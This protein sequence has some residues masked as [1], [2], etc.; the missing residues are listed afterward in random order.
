MIHVLNR[1]KGGLLTVSILTIAVTIV[2]ILNIPISLAAVETNNWLFNVPANYIYDSGKVEVTGGEAILKKT[3]FQINDDEKTEF[4][5]GTYSETEWSTDHVQLASNEIKPTANTVGLWHLNNLGGL[6]LD[7]TGNGNHATNF[8]AGRGETGVYGNSFS[9]DGSAG[10]TEVSDSIGLDNMSALT[11]EAWVYPTDVTGENIILNKETTYEMGINGGLF[12]VAIQTDSMGWIWLGTKSVSPNTW[13]HVAATYDGSVIKLYINGLY[14]EQFVWVGGDV[15]DSLSDLRFGRRGA[16]SYFDGKLDEVAVWNSALNGTEIAEHAHL[17][18][19]EINGDYQSQV[20]DGGTDLSWEE[21]SWTENLSAYS[22]WW[23]TSWTKRQLVEVDNTGYSAVLSDY[24]VKVDVAFDGDMNADFSD[25]RFV[26]STGTTEFDYWVSEYTPSVSA[27]VYVKMPAI[28]ASS[29]TNMQM[30][31]GNALATGNS[32]PDGTLLFFDDFDSNTTLAYSSHTHESHSGGGSWTWDTINSWLSNGG[33]NDCMSLIYNTGLAAGQVYIETFNERAVIDND[34]VGLGWVDAGNNAHGASV[35][36]GDHGVGGF[37]RVPSSGA[38]VAL[39]TQDPAFNHASSGPFRLATARDQDGKIYSWFNGVANTQN[40]FDDS[41]FTPS[42][43]ALFSHAMS[44]SPYYSYFFARKYITPEPSASFLVEETYGSTNVRFQ[45]R[46]CDDAICNGETYVGPDGTGATFYSTASG[47]NLNVSNN[48]YFQYKAYLSASSS[49]FTP[50][51]STVTVDSYAYPDDLPM[52]EPVTSLSPSQVSSWQTFIET[53]VKP[54]GTNIYYQLSDDDGVTWYFWDSSAWVVAG[55][56]DY[57]IAATVNNK[58]SGFPAINQ[59]LIYRAFLESSS[60]DTPRLNNIRIDYQGD[61]S[62]INCSND[63]DFSVVGDYNYNSTVI[64]VSGGKAELLPVGVN[65]VDDDQSEFDNGSY[66]QIN[67]DTDHLELAAAQ[68]SGMYT[69]SIKNAGSSVNWQSLSWVP[70]WPIGKEMPNSK[71]VETVYAEKN[72]DMS[73]NRLL[74]H[75]NES[76]GVIVDSSGEGNDGADN[77]GI[78]YAQTGKLNNAVGFDGSNDYIQLSDNMD[79]V[80]GSGND[81]WTISTWI[82]PTV[83]AAAQSNHSTQ[84]VFFAKAS[85]ANNDNLELGITP[86]GN[87]YAYIDASGND[88]G[89]QFGSGELS[90]NKWHH[91]AVR[92]DSGTVDVWLDGNNYQ[93]TTTWAASN[94]MDAAVGSPITIGATI[95]TDTFF[96]GL[97]D[98]VAVFDSALADAVVNDIYT[99]GVESLNYQVRSCDDGLCSGE[100]FIG[101]DGTAS[102]YYSERMSSTLGLPALTLT[103]VVPNQ[104]FQYKAGFATDNVAYSPE[105]SSVTIM[106][107]GSSFSENA[108]EIVPASLYTHADLYQLTD[109]EE[110]AVKAANSEIYYQISNNSMDW[111]W[112]NGVTWSDIAGGIMSDANTISLWHL[113]GSGGSV[114]DV[115]S[116]NN[117]GVNNG[118]VRGVVGK[119]GNAFDFDGVDDYVDVPYAPSLN[120]GGTDFTIDFWINTTDSDGIII[121]K[122]TGSIGGDSWGVR[123]NGGII[124]FYDGITWISSGIVANDGSWKHVAITADD[125]SNSLEFFENGKSFGS[126]T[127]S[128]ITPNAQNVFIGSDLASSHFD[129]MLDELRI[130]NKVRTDDEIL[131]SVWLFNTATEVAANIGSY[132]VTANDFVFKSF[133][134]S[135]GVDQAALDN[136]RLS[137]TYSTSVAPTATVPLNMVQATDGSGYVA[138]DVTVSDANSDDTKLKVE[139]SDDNGANFYDAEI[140]SAGVNSGTVDVDNSAGYQIGSLDAIDSFGGAVDLTVIWDTKSFN[141]GN[142]SLDA[143]DISDI[144]LRVIPNDFGLDGSYSTSASFG[145]DNLSPFGLANLALNSVATDSVSVSFDSSTV[146]NNFNHY[147]LW[148]GTSQSDVDSRSG[149]AGVWNDSHDAGLANMSASSTTITGLSSSTTYFVKIWSVDDFG[150]EETVALVSDTTN[151]LAAPAGGGGGGGGGGGSSS[152]YTI[153]NKEIEIVEGLGES[154][155]DN[156]HA[157]AACLAYDDERS[158]VFSDLNEDHWGYRF[159]DF[160]KKVKMVSQDQYVI[161]GYAN[162]DNDELAEVG[163]DNNVKRY[164]LVKMVLGANCYAI[165]N[166]IS[167]EGDNLFEFS[168]LPRSFNE[169]DALNYA[170]RVMYTALDY[171]IIQGYS[172]GSARPFDDVNRAEATKIILNAAGIDLSVEPLSPEDIDQRPFIDVNTDDWF[173]QFIDYAFGKGIVRGYEDDPGYFHPE[174][175][176]QRAASAKVVTLSMPLSQKVDIE[177]KREVFNRFDDIIPYEPAYEVVFDGDEDPL[178]KKIGVRKNGD[179]AV[180]SSELYAGEEDARFI[181]LDGVVLGAYTERAAENWYLIVMVMVFAG[182][183]AETYYIFRKRKKKV[184]SDDSEL[185]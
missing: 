6:V 177:M 45:V 31:Y 183:V 60:A 149:G 62:T 160:L 86:A 145:V 43:I 125:A 83:L 130:S 100:T 163:P 167:G 169:D 105:L 131:R 48:R 133:L 132:S 181:V 116:Y 23:N 22:D 58:I 84:N 92:Y 25:L 161:S 93:N 158:L 3:S 147:E 123:L 139:Y 154:E 68:S 122:Y 52:I 141:N 151:A 99:R 11:M 57:N 50:E 5:F 8:G 51:L 113:N 95:H 156:L 34:G 82:N 121:K 170:R 96:N 42:K 24:Q 102:T 114:L 16:A 9:F 47:E 118:T 44:P 136:V 184:E 1:K 69:S 4:D 178:G 76:S 157:A 29:V 168:D 162:P 63:W 18:L 166:D 180:D 94:N 54:A 110:I 77:G 32:D 53:A 7:A 164:E 185:L 27:T 137:C 175:T 98:E 153:T 140:V 171:D 179:D 14:Q 41:A 67:Y 49:S 79:S 73:D 59:Q 15:V 127:F 150:N 81:T 97:I 37:V 176:M 20:F 61:I 10:Y 138:F 134:K 109:F 173:Y 115:S 165:K 152:Q 13:T 144:Q 28:S 142:G 89:A 85:D 128:D 126:A 2:N 124:E 65:F 111:N 143:F 135:D 112:W 56:G 70:G 80:F 87:L 106:T 90:I 21:I 75:L 155:V 55:A 119:Y 40:G 159:L 148:Y 146:E 101:P 19:Y 107:D 91:V 172:D 129:G 39:T 12:K 74:L 120:L 17:G 72:L 88:V 30:Y 36:D 66:T 71:Q 46:S 108:P 35:Y 26:D 103:N 117:S 64:D 182:V 38:P 174:R 33:S 104:Y 78:T